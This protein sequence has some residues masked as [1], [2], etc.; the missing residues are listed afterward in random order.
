MRREVLAFFPLLCQI[1]EDRR[2]LLDIYLFHLPRYSVILK[3]ILGLKTKEAEPSCIYK[4][5]WESILGNEPYAPTESITP[6]MKPQ[7]DTKRNL[8][9]RDNEKNDT[10]ESYCLFQ[11]VPQSVHF[12]AM[13]KE[14][15][16]SHFS[17]PVLSNDMKNSTK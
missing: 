4:Y 14:Y 17:I 12:Q 16:D 15:L 13:D 11:E 5:V 6:F 3:V 8:F 10:Q 1:F 7:S 9:Q 2:W